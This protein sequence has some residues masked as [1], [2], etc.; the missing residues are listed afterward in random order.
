MTQITTP[1]LSHQ[2]RGGSFMQFVYSAEVGSGDGECL[3]PP[4]GVGMGVGS[5]N[6]GRRGRGQETTQVFVTYSLTFENTLFHYFLGLISATSIP[7]KILER[8]M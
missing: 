5:M 2:D 8:N 6:E 4:V 1:L 3:V 7:R